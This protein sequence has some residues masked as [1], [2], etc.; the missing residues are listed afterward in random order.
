MHEYIVNTL[1]DERAPGIA[2]SYILCQLGMSQLARLSVNGWKECL[3]DPDN[4]G[5]QVVSSLLSAEILN[6]SEE[7]KTQ[8]PEARTLD[9]VFEDI[10]TR[11][12]AE[13]IIEGRV[14]WVRYEYDP[15]LPGKDPIERFIPL[16]I[17]RERCAPD[18]DIYGD[19]TSL[20]KQ[21]QA[22]SE[23]LFPAFIDCCNYP[24]E[25]E[26]DLA[27]IDEIMKDLV[28]DPEEVVP[29]ALLPRIQVS[30]GLVPTVA[31]CKG[32]NDLGVALDGMRAS[33]ENLFSESEEV[34]SEALQPIYQA[35]ESLT[36]EFEHLE[37]EETLISAGVIELK[38]SE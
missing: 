16:A 20:Q 3:A 27:S 12:A 17:L 14:A 8:Y 6:T 24:D 18:H 21:C 13:D 28:S 9:E 11:F 34:V 38:P 33:M 37:G 2:A 30:E 10:G 22:V 35:V 25:F 23:E 1:I 31:C 15:D 26:E 29:E 36:M 4:I 32:P 19:Q 5:S 7:V